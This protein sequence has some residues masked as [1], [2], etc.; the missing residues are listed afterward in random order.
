MIKK[1]QELYT[2]GGKTADEIRAMN[3]HRRRK[4]SIELMLRTEIEHHM[5]KEVEKKTGIPLTGTDEQKC[6]FAT[7]LLFRFDM[8]CCRL[9]ERGVEFLPF[10]VSLDGFAQTFDDSPQ[11][12]AEVK[13]CFREWIHDPENQWS[14]LPN[15]KLLRAYFTFDI[16]N[17]PLGNFV[18]TQHVLLFSGGGVVPDH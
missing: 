16:P 11:L 4:A 1:L 12:Q 13:G 15:L 8:T 17:L 3:L 10:D 2:I 9:L 6:E 7:E 18:K 14:R 5:N